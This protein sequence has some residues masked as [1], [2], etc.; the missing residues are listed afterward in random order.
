MSLQRPVEELVR[1]SCCSQELA[2]LVGESPLFLKSIEQLPAIAKS[3]ASVLISGETGTGKELVAQLIHQLGTR[4]AFAFV[5]VNCGSFSDALLEDELFGHERGAFT[6]AER[7]RNGLIAQAQCGTLFLDEVD[8]MPP[9]AQ[10][11]LLRVLQDKKF[12]TIGSTLERDADVR[13]VAATNVALDQLVRTNN[14]RAD[15][16]YRLRV[17]SINLPP[18]RDRR[19]DITRL[20]A[21]FLKKHAPLHKPMPK[22][23]PNALAALMSRDWPGNVRELENTIIRAVHLSQGDFIELADLGLQSGFERPLASIFYGPGKLPAYRTI[24]REA[25]ALFEKDYLTRLMAEHIGN[26]TRAA[27]SAGKDR[28]DLGKLLKKHGVDARVFRLRGIGL[29]G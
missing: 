16:Y 22:L 2:N 3:Q 14:F 13:V 8:T 17:F 27:R 12:R 23:A 18:L 5:A 28:S 6:G 19:E 20:A 9:K 1:R 29:P 7:C 25:V 26:V 21:Y 24:K 11:D 4:A 15:L 10:I